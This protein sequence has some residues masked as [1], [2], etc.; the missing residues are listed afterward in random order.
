V[1]APIPET[2]VRA[3]V[4][5]WLAAQNGGDFASYERLYAERFTGIKRTG[6]RERS[7][8]RAAW[9]ADRARMFAAPIQVTA[10]DLAVT[11]HGRTA[12]VRF[13][14]GFTR[15]RFHDEGDK[16]LVVVAGAGGL[17]IARE[18]MLRSTV[19]PSGPTL[20]WPILEVGSERYVVLDDVTVPT[21]TAPFEA[22][23][24]GPGFTR[25][26]RRALPAGAAAAPASV[27]VYPGGAVCAVA[28]R[29]VLAVGTPHFGEEQAWRDGDLDQDGTPE[30]APLSE[31]QKHELGAGSA[32]LAGLLGGCAGGK[33]ALPGAGVE[34]RAIEDDAL[35]GR[36]AALY[37]THDAVQAIQREWEASGGAGPWTVEDG[38][39]EI[40]ATILEAPGGRR[41]V[42]VGADVGDGCGDFEGSLYLVLGVV[43]SKLEP[44]GTTSGLPDVAVAPDATSLPV[45]T[46]GHRMTVPEAGRYGEARELNLGFR[47]CPC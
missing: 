29:Y 22:L 10:T 3:L 17:V 2:E 12:T 15:G 35:G 26:G 28:A 19:K 18:E 4:D 32:M 30:A 16:E 43:G 23:S 41:I 25:A 44:L 13:V 5:R 27:H 40:R 39:S 31:A 14:Q 37:A 36:A 6:P 24:D 1:I 42:V 46:D 38:D 11:T 7:F 21:S 34:W 33:V 20:A 45:L 9:L 8:D 47:D